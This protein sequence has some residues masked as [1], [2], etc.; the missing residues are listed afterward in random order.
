M[1]F[2]VLL[3]LRA[4]TRQ[5]GEIGIAFMLG[6]ALLRFVSEFF[7]EPEPHSN[8]VW[9]GITLAQVLCLIM[10]SVGIGLLVYSRTRE[11]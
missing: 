5:P 2:A 3:M 11:T 6:Y 10:F 7:R 8:F 9:H 4:K 1:P